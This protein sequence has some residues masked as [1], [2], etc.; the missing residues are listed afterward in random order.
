VPDGVLARE[1]AHLAKAR[2]DL[3]RMREHTRDL[4]AGEAQWGNDELTSRALTAELGRRYDALLDDGVTP[5]FFG[6]LDYAAVAEQPAEVFHVGRRHVTGSDGEPVVVD[7]RAP[8]SEPFYRASAGDPLGVALRRRF[9]FR[10]GALTAY[11]DDRLDAPTTSS[12]LLVE[13]IERPR[14]GPMRD[15]VATIQPDQD[16]LVRAPLEQTVCVQGAPGTGKTAVGLHRA[17]YLLYAYRQR[18]AATGVLVVGPNRAFLSYVQEVLPALGEVQV[19]QLTADELAP[20]VRVRATDGEAA[21]VLKGDA[22]MAT[23]LERA[24]WL[25]ASRASEPLV[26]ASGARRWRVQPEQ[27]RELER[28]VRGRRLGWEAGRAALAGSLAAAVVRQMEDAGLSLSDR[29]VERLARSP[30]VKA[31]VDG[32]W[33]PV[34]AASLVF[35]VLADRDLLARAGDRLLDEDEQRLLTWDPV[36]T[37]VGRVRWSRADLP[38]LDEATHLLLRSGGYAHVVLD[39]AQDLSAMQLRAVGR[40]CLTGSATVLGDLAQATTPWAARDWFT[41]LGHLG[42]PAGLVESLT[43]GY[44]VPREVLELAN[45]LLPVI[46]PDLPA[47]RSLRHVPGALTVRRV[48]AGQ[49]AATAAGVVAGRSGSGSVAV[50]AADRLLL[51]AVG[52]ELAGRGIDADDLSVTGAP[53]PVSLVPAELVKG[54]EFDHV[55]LLEPADLAAVGA[56]GLR[57]L[58]VALTRA[59]S[60]LTVVHAADLP[61]ALD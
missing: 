1:R 43:L 53:A 10:E 5:L 31:Y 35:S 9:G 41:V 54:L 25:R 56:H 26:H 28:A 59:V 61:A 2:A 42:K 40:R 44:R 18:L 8:I 22:R 45:R 14:T 51:A 27:A 32:L 47:A 16:V 34:T 24:L 58:Y 46:A 29:T 17:A 15:I 21:A 36:P 49:R 7:W 11:E 38:L 55:V 50:V 12:A 19:T 33:P 39:E 4:L 57:L 23:V 6:R 20:A 37:T 60:S 30:D 52:G 48:A 13:E 3:R